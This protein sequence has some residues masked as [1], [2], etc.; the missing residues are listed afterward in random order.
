MGAVRL[1]YLFNIFILNGCVM[2]LG[3]YEIYLSLS[4]SEY[5]EEVNVSSFWIIR[6]NFETLLCRWSSYKE[7]WKQL[8]VLS[9]NS[10]LSCREY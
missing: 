3:V 1:F 4:L 10:H 8:I 2:K 6:T 5:F 9:T 7:S